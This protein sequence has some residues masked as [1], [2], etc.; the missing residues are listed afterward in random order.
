[1]KKIVVA[2]GG[3][4]GHLYPAI[5]VVEELLKEYKEDI[6]F[7]FIGSK[8]K[9]EGRVVPELGY[10]FQ[11]LELKEFVRFFHFQPYCYLSKF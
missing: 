5:A 3:T 2:A 10:R 6:E 7:V 4:G 11:H 1:M 8:N 9:I